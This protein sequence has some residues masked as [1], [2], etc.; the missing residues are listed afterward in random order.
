MADV[1]NAKCEKFV[2]PL[3]VTDSSSGVADLGNGVADLDSEVAEY[4]T[5]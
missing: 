1:K 5:W 2:T 4:R 3:P